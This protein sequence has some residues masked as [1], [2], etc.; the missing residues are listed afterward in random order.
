MKNALTVLFLLYTFYSYS[1]IQPVSGN[2]NF[3]DFEISIT[4]QYPAL[5]PS[6]SGTG[7]NVSCN[8]QF[9][10]YT[11]RHIET[12]RQIGP[13]SQSNAELTLKGIWQLTVSGERE[14]ILCQKTFEFEVH[15]LSES[16]GIKRYFE[17]TGFISI[18]I[19]RT[20]VPGLKS[21]ESK[22]IP[23]TLSK[24]RFQEEGNE[25]IYLDEAFQLVFREFT[26]ISEIEPEYNAVITESNS[27]GEQGCLCDLVLEDLLEEYTAGTVNIWGHQFFPDNNATGGILFLKGRMPGD[28]TLPANAT[29]ENQIL[30][31]LPEILSF[32]TQTLDQGRVILT[33]LFLA[34]PIQGHKN[35]SLCNLPLSTTDNYLTP[36]G[37]PIKI[38]SNDYIGYI[39]A[40]GNTEGV[41][42]GVITWIKST[43]SIGEG[44]FQGYRYQNNKFE[45]YIDPVSG[46]LYRDFSASELTD[47][48]TVVRVFSCGI[49]CKE[50]YQNI[51]NNALNF[52][53][54]GGINFKILTLAKNPNTENQSASPYIYTTCIPPEL[55]SNGS[56]SF[57]S[58]NKSI[59]SLPC[60]SVN[61]K[62]I[63]DIELTY[64]AVTENNTFDYSIV[65]GILYKFSLLEDGVVSQ[66][67]YSFTSN[68]YVS[69]NGPYQI[70]PSISNSSEFIFSLPCGDQHKLYKLSNLGGLP[71]YENGSS[72]SYYDKFDQFAEEFKPFSPSFPLVGSGV[73]VLTSNSCLWCPG[74]ITSL[75]TSGRCETPEHIYLDKIAQVATVFESYFSPPELGE[76]QVFTYD[77]IY[78]HLPQSGILHPL[79]KRP[80]WE[81][82]LSENLDVKAKYGQDNAAFF[83]IVLEKLMDFITQNSFEF[84]EK[85]T[86]STIHT[87][88][89]HE[90]Y[91]HLKYEP[92]IITS[93]VDFATKKQLILEKYFQENSF[94]ENNEN[95]SIH[96]LASVQGNEQINDALSYIETKGVQSFWDNFG[97]FY[98]LDNKTRIVLTISRLINERQI[99]EPYQGVENFIPNVN[100]N[101]ATQN[102]PVLEADILR[103][104]NLN[105]SFTGPNTLNIESLGPV[106]YKTIVPVEVLGTVEFDGEVI[107]SHSVLFIPAL[108]VK[109]MSHLNTHDVFVNSGW[110]ALDLGFLYLGVGAAR[111]AWSAAK[112]LEKAI[113]ASDIAGSSTGIA[114]NLLNSSVLNPD[115]KRYLQIASLISASPLVITEVS[116]LHNIIHTNDLALDNPSISASIRN[117]VSEVS[118]DIIDNY[119]NAAVIAEY[120]TLNTSL[121]DLTIPNQKLLKRDLFFNN[122]PLFYDVLN[123]Q[124]GVKAWEGLINTGLRTNIKWL[125]TTSKWID[126][127]LELTS[128]ASKVTIKKAGVEVGE[129]SS[130]LLKVKY[131]GLGGDIVSHPTKTTSA[132]GRY[133]LTGGGAGTKNLIESGLT[134]SGENAGGI[135]VLNDL[136]NIQGWPDQQI[137]DQINKP[138][139]DAAIGRGDVIR[140]VSDPT[141]PANLFK[142]GISGELTFF[143]REH[144]HLT[145]VNGY[146]YNASTFTYTK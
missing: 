70:N 129:I 65:S 13:S 34:H 27:T 44:Y 15:D 54:D 133:Q 110:T 103:W 97:H 17:N 126:D 60:L 56:V 79:K 76:N 19:F 5:C 118:D 20:D 14:G 140:A 63:Q 1:Q 101:Y 90:I 112:F 9:D 66:Y 122:D 22:R 128:T 106:S 132:I 107:N 77:D 134:K 30:S 102:P 43:G 47:I 53:I 136:T 55:V 88:S 104:D 85:V 92:Q 71:T 3:P 84:W 52:K 62:E 35:T 141:L 38:Q 72:I 139:I 143:G 37:V 91:N 121:L 50:V 127:G 64:G 57:L 26:P 31:L 68:T 40:E 114:A 95:A 10:S 111:R 41:G 125:E 49:G 74:Q 75:I 113:I 142:D 11:W 51:K 80:F 131:S 2:F 24:T 23:C 115:Q 67:T 119:Y 86:P 12:N 94:D 4:P 135:N 78:W 83:K 7:V 16:S 32:N 145:Q 105:A 25:D 28:Q 18:P 93:A 69:N 123:G 120:S 137:W 81:V 73:S 58:P 138:W 116:R 108:Q 100:Q 45:G 82:Y 36:A 99:T 144:F 48:N 130:D 6:N 98:N 109:L 8:E 61:C 89:N 59:I 21:N 46:Q 42:E 39:A 87:L 117:S 29:H 124:N 146:I 96:L 33:N